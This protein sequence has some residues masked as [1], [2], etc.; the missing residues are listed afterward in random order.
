MSKIIIVFFIIL[1]IIAL[2]FYMNVY[3]PK[4]DYIPETNY[5]E[6]PVLPKVEYDLEGKG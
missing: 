5:K 1:G 2:Y 3:K 4:V 6:L